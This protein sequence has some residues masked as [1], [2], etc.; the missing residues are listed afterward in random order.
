MNIISNH[1]FS[2]FI[3]NSDFK[4]VLQDLEDK[5]ITPLIT[6]LWNKM[7]TLSKNNSIIVTWLPSNIGIHENERVDKAAKK[8]S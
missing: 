6:R 2:K 4:S 3:I 8:H 5:N 7:N 1:K